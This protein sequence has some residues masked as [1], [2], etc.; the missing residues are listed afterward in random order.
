[1]AIVRVW[2]LDG[3]LASGV[4]GPLDVFAAANALAL[5]AGVHERPIEW[6]VE[7]PDGHDVRSASGMPIAADGVIGARGC[8]DAVLVTA[9][10]VEEMDS[11]ISRSAELHALTHALQAR[12]K[13]GAVIATYCTGSYLLAEA[14]LLDGKIATTHW[15]KARDFKR[16]YPRVQ[17]KA[18]EILTEQ[19]GI[20]CG[21]AATSF[22]NLAVRLVGVFAGEWLARETAKT[23]LID[24]NRVSQ[25][26]HAR[27]L[28][29]HGHSDRLIANAQRWMEERLSQGFSLPK[30]ATHLAVSERT[31]S[32]RFRNVLGMTPLEYLQA[33]RVEVAKCLLE[34]GRTKLDDISE[35]V[36]YGDT[37]TFRQLFKRMTGVSPR[38]YRGMFASR[39]ESS[40]T[41]P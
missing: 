10:F 16:R 6:R 11:F 35:R 38:E 2:A 14:G 36:G 25:A 34:E 37:G 12:H 4:F 3:V 40:G 9:P 22:L 20:I 8:A 5:R 24:M 15:A 27:L 7:T 19:D 33:L 28:Q 29:E 1:M 32:R 21:G 26:S 39:G 13:A 30:L 17:V 41:I 18:N 23:L 31:L